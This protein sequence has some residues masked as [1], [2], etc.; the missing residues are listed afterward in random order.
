MVESLW[1]SDYKGEN[2]Y[3][4]Q[5]YIYNILAKK[6]AHNKPA[7]KVKTKNTLSAQ[8]AISL[9]IEFEKEIDEQFDRI[10][11]Q[12]RLIPI[13]K[14]REIERENFIFLDNEKADWDAEA[15]KMAAISQ[16]VK[17]ENHTFDKNKIRD[18]QKIDNKAKVYYDG[19]AK[20]FITD[21]SLEDQEKHE[22]DRIGMKQ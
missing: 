15:K 4:K 8:E 2:A 1:T 12:E 22:N 3:K 16:W 6:A 17:G 19:M 18:L 13:I 10:Q 14:K 11:R 7:G 9:K 21:L 20:K 5:G